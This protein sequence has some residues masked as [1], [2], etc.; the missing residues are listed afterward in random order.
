[1]ETGWL[2]R[3]KEKPTGRGL[4]GTAQQTAPIPSRIVACEGEAPGRVGS[5]K[6]IG[7]DGRP[8]HG[9][10]EFGA[11]VSGQGGRGSPA[12]ERRRP[13]RLLSGAFSPTANEYG[14]YA[15]RGNGPKSAKSKY[16]H[17]KARA[18]QNRRNGKRRAN[19]IC[20]KLTRQVK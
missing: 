11:L 12:R 4:S 9:A 16:S 6:K 7:R 17:K 5:V 19:Y 2:R 18:R 8:R 13:S 1:M 15:Y 20:E 14:E 10:P 3:R